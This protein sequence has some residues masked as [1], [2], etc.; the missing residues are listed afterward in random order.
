MHC[1]SRL[2]FSSRGMPSH[3]SC[4]YG[5]CVWIGPRRST[6]PRASGSR[7]DGYT[8]PGAH[9]GR[10]IGVPVSSPLSL[11]LGSLVVPEPA[12]AVVPASASDV[13][14]RLGGAGVEPPHAI[15]PNAAA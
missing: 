2:P 8:T 15:G 3:A 5:E 11:V 4:E 14:P 12:I 6:K 1:A 10:G 9:G 13:V 7:V